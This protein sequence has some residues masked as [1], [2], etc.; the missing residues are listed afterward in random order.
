MTRTELI[1]VGSPAVPYTYLV[2]GERNKDISFP[3]EA[4]SQPLLLSVQIFYWA[5]GETGLRGYFIIKGT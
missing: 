2:L 1:V 4:E 3:Q 5:R